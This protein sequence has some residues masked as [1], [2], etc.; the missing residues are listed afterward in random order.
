MYNDRGCVRRWT[1]YYAP[2]RGVDVERRARRRQ[3]RPPSHSPVADFETSNTCPKEEG[4]NFARA[5]TATGLLSFGSLSDHPESLW[6][7]VVALA[8]LIDTCCGSVL[9]SVC[10]TYPSPSHHCASTRQS[11]SGADL[12]STIAD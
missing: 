8:S 3:T 4:L 11:A 2:E 10:P 5:L 1:K 6:G 12:G 7:P 9:D